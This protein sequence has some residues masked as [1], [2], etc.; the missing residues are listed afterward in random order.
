[1]LVALRQNRFFVGD[2]RGI[3]RA[4]L[5]YSALAV[6]QRDH[7]PKTFAGLF[8]G[9]MGGISRSSGTQRVRYGTRR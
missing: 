6:S 8:H 5:E 2:E 4:P 1:M 7:E 9:L 3:V